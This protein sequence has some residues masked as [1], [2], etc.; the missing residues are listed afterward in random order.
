VI[1]FYLLILA[2]LHNLEQLV[3]DI[4]ILDV[5]VHVHISDDLIPEQLGFLE[6]NIIMFAKKLEI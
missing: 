6:D 3:Y 4:V 2:L 5:V 1:V